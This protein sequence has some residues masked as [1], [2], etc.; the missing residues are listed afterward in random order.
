MSI[1][2]GLYSGVSGLSSQ[3]NAMA[4]IG[5]NI[6]NMNTIGF[7]GSSICFEDMLAQTI[8][9]ASG[10]SQV[11]RG[12]ALSSVTAS[13]QQGSFESTSRP[14]D[15][16]IGGKGFFVV[17]AQGAQTNYY[18]R[19]GQFSFDPEGYFVN[20]AGYIVQGW[21]LDENGQDMG[22]I[23]DIQ[24]SSFTSAPEPTSRISI[25]A[26]LDSSAISKSTDSLSDRWDGTATAS[27]PIGPTDYTYQTSLTAYDSLGTSHDLTVYYDPTATDNKWD[28]I[29][30]C[31][32]GEDKRSG[33]PVAQS[34][35][36]ARGTVTFNASG[37]ISVLDTEVYDGTSSWKDATNS[38]TGYPQFTASFITGT[39]QTIELNIGTR[40]NGTAWANEALSST[41]Y[42][43]ASTTVFQTQNGYESGM[44]QSLSVD[45]DGVITGQYS[46]GQIIGLYRVA[47]ANFNNPGGLSKQGGNLYA[48]T[49][50]SGDRITGHPGSGGLGQISPNSLEQS[51][52][53]LGTEFV[54]MIT[55]QRGFQANSRIITTINDMLS[56]LINLKR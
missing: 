48:V 10:T 34:G 37:A 21:E 40:W 32:P 39:D 53:D 8:N 15:L 52:V 30:T 29:V 2:S 47:L 3:A 41:Q 36:L 49:R 23:T 6:A 33:Y 43:S 35:L 4:V 5:D 55:N 54:R 25:M 38:A 56:E 12:V 13:F 31:N 50:A 22:S 45:V 28:F 14:T 18:T 24:V 17:R 42:A 46:N 44:L 16:A 20:P 26:N 27:P 9:T 51:N 7:K 19:A 1:I 11:G